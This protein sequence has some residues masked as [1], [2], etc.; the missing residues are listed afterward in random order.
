MKELFTRQDST[1]KPT[2]IVRQILDLIEKGELTP[3]EK[4]PNE[5]EIVKQTDVSRASVREAF[6]ALELMGIIKRIPG[7]GTFISENA[8]A[9]K[10]T[11]RIILEKF[12]ED[13][14]SVG[15]S[16]EALEARMAIEPSVAVM[17]ARR[18]EP[19]QIERI[20]RLITDSE[21]ALEAHD[22]EKFLDIDRE[23]HIAVAD[24][25]NNE[26]LQKMSRELLE[27]ADVHMW[28]RYKEDLGLLEKT[29]DAHKQILNAI[30]ER[31]PAKAAFYSEKHLARCV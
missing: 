22:V 14:E 28:R 23:F 18:A 24:A 5:F 21:K 4:L 8:Y 11:S 16:F 25:T 7:E 2:I 17:A 29:V 9:G 12:L 3:G 1:K 15:G 20:E 13:T 30:K 10:Y 6:S 26:I 19:E 31:D 27:K